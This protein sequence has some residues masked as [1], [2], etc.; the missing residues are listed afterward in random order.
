MIEDTILG[1]LPVELASFATIG[2]LPG[3][4][5]N[6]VC[7][8]FYDGASNIEYFG[9]RHES[10][11]FQPIMKCVIRNSSYE[12]AMN[13]VESIKEALHRYSDAGEGVEGPILSILM[14]GSP[15]YLGRDEQKFH[16]FQMTFTIQTKE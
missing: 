11:I 15:M 14:I 5:K 1:L 3:T 6:C 8:I 16:T 9:A 13:W 10:T 4:K 12:N 7:L 2:D